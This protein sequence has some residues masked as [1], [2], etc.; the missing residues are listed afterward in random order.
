MHQQLNARFCRNWNCASSWSRN[1]TQRQWMATV[2]CTTPSSMVNI[3]T[4]SARLV[5]RHYQPHSGHAK[6]VAHIRTHR[7]RGPWWWACT[8]TDMHCC[9]GYQVRSFR[10]GIGAIVTSAVRIY[11]GTNINVAPH[12]LSHQDVHCTYTN[13]RFPWPHWRVDGDN[14]TLTFLVRCIELC[15]ISFKHLLLTA[16]TYRC[17][18]IKAHKPHVTQ[19]VTDTT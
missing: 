8:K 18:I 13:C 19:I 5:H 15:L 2:L 10:I 17:T 11:H 4:P 6:T 14:D 3:Q 9:V 1:K 12:L 16:M 7:H